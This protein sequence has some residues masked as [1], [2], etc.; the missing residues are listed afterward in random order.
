MTNRP[1]LN[2]P[3]YLESKRFI[4]EGHQL[5]VRGESTVP[6]NAEEQLRMELAWAD[7]KENELELLDG[8]AADLFMLLGEERNQPLDHEPKST[9]DL[10]SRV[11]H[12]FFAHNWVELLALLRHGPTSW[13]RDQIALWRG[14]AWQGLGEY[15]VALLFF[16]YASKVKPGNTKAQYLSLHALLKLGRI[17]EA[18]KRTEEYAD[19]AIVNTAATIPLVAAPTS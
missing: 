4:I 1:S 12:A 16:D 7:L 8:L 15:D 10:S 6:K 19:A 11:F 3:P 17:D 13:P 2:N 9:D 14:E 5:L 18:L